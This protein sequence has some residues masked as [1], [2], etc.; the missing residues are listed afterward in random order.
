MGE[1]GG[2]NHSNVGSS[3]PSND[4]PYQK[5]ANHVNITK[6]NNGPSNMDY[7]YGTN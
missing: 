4:I 1:G 6:R 5:V 3:S 7:S 2:I